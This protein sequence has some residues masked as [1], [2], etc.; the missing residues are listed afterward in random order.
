MALASKVSILERLDKVVGY[1]DGVLELGNTAAQ[2]S[3]YL[4][5]ITN[6][7]GVF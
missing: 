2:V 5:V 3:G 1:F 7:K 6:A 4:Q